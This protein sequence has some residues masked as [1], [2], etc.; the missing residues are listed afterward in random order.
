M[1][2]NFFSALQDVWFFVQLILCLAIRSVNLIEI[3]TWWINSWLITLHNHELILRLTVFMRSQLKNKRGKMFL[4]LQD[5]CYGPTEL[6]ASVL[7]ISYSESVFYSVFV[8]S[9]WWE[10]GERKKEKVIVMGH[11]HFPL[12]QKGPFSSLHLEQIPYTGHL[13]RRIQNIFIAKIKAVAV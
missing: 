1:I 5:L 2:R 7:P 3:Q 6:K 11:F 8:W 4:P 12:Q 9:H 10:R 13:S